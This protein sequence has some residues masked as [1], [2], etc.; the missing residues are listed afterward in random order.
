MTPIPVLLQKERPITPITNAGPVLL[1]NGQRYSALFFG[2]APFLYIEATDAAPTGKP[3]RAPSDAERMTAVLEELLP[4]RR[5]AILD[6]TADKT[7]KGN[8]DGTT[9]AA[10]SLSPL[11]ADA[12]V[13]SEYTVKNS[14][15]P[16]TA[17]SRNARRIF[18]P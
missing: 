18:L 2:M 14:E 12:Y 4:V 15:S 6:A 1:Q 8:N 13:A 3:H 7:I 10:H 11:I 5:E 17:S 16:S 9:A